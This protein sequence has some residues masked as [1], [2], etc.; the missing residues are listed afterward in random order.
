MRGLSLLVILVAGV[1]VF[2]GCAAIG[3]YMADPRVFNA[4]SAAAQEK[5][6]SAKDEELLHQ[7]YL[8]L[9]FGSL[10]PDDHGRQSARELSS[11]QIEAGEET[12][13]LIQPPTVIFDNQDRYHRIHATV[14]DTSGR[15]PDGWDFVLEPGSY[16]I[17]PNGDPEA[18]HFRY[19][20]TYLVTYWRE[21]P[22][23]VYQTRPDLETISFQ[24]RIKPRWST[25]FKTNYHYGV[26]FL[27]RQRRW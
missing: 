22:R 24:V 12:T 27:P 11:V 1:V 17:Y 14:E 23:L 19:R 9:P 4:A 8:E 2:C 18:A 21:D 20:E 6:H 3:P 15:E 10:E 5:F 25:V 26:R 13:L 7:K 16:I